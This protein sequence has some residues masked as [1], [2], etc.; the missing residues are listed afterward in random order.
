M[1]QSTHRHCE[2]CFLDLF[3]WINL[4]PLKRL[5]KEKMNVKNKKDYRLIFFSFLFSGKRHHPAAKDFYQVELL[6]FNKR[7]A[8]EEWMWLV[9]MHVSMHSLRSHPVIGGSL[10]EYNRLPFSQKPPTDGMNNWQTAAADADSVPISTATFSASTTQNL[11]QVTSLAKQSL[12]ALGVFSANCAT[13]R[14][15]QK[16][17]SLYLLLLQIVKTPCLQMSVNCNGTICTLI[18]NAIG[19]GFQ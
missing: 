17:I 8:A 7:C 2:H 9:V 19:R 12:K 3:I 14:S 6:I 11:H 10:Q 4:S 15:F 1:T 13:K 5:V 18:V 16:P